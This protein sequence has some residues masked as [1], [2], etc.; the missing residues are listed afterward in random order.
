MFHFKGFCVNS[1]NL[2][3]CVMNNRNSSTYIGTVH[4]HFYC[5]D[6]SRELGDRVRLRLI[7]EG[8]R[9][10]VPHVCSYHMLK[11]NDFRLQTYAVLGTSRPF[12]YEIESD[13]WR[14]GPSLYGWRM[15]VNWNVYGIIRNSFDCW[16]FVV[17]FRPRDLLYDWGFE[18]TNIWQSL[19][20]K[21]AGNEIPS[22][23]PRPKKMNTDEAYYL[24]Y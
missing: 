5:F 14:W 3:V 24:Y 13:H 21:C 23:L 7:T 15:L 22:K 16:K 11:Y 4:Q 8:D 9:E 18:I 6:I 2:L 17:G 20:I 1:L 10:L 12:I 19:L